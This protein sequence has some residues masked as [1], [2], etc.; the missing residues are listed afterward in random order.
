MNGAIASLHPAYFALVMAT[1]IVSI[2]C[3]LLGMRAIA[4][5]M[6]WLNIVF[7]AALWLVAPPRSC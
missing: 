2:A 6:L 3:D 4:M 7:Y 1:G 5:V